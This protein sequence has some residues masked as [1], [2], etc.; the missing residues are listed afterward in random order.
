M[1]S[2]TDHKKP[3]FFLLFTGMATGMA[4]YTLFAGEWAAWAN[5]VYWVGFTTLTCRYIWCRP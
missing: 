1:E 3:S 4:I 5:D 2:C